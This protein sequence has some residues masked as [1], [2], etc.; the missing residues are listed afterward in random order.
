[1]ILVREHLAREAETYSW[2]PLGCCGSTTNVRQT[3][4]GGGDVLGGGYCD[5]TCDCSRYDCWRGVLVL[6]VFGDLPHP[7]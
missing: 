4:N 7:P 3:S 6:E 1:M 5:G 2:A